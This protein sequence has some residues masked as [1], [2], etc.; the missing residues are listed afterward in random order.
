MKSPRHSRRRPKQTVQQGFWFGEAGESTVPRRCRRMRER[1]LVSPRLLHSASF[2]LSLVFVQSL[3]PPIRIVRP[4]LERTCRST[5]LFPA[6]QQ[7]P[8]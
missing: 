2:A 8:L 1:L 5:L 6:A 7:F 3:L 4:A